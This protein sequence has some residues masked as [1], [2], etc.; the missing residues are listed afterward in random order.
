LAIA[1]SVPHLMV[2]A[3]GALAADG[4]QPQELEEARDSVDALCHC[5][6]GAGRAGREVP[7][8][9]GDAECRPLRTVTRIQMG[10]SYLYQ[11]LLC[12]PCGLQ[13]HTHQTFE[14]LSSHKPRH[15]NGSPHA[16][17]AHARSGIGG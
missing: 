16:R 14:V 6:R 7:S 12:S 10:R 15:E 13:N 8:A 11:S 9:G 2:A 17:F 1:S 3:A 4:A 5:R